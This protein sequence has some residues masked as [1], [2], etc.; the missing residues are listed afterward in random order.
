MSDGDSTQTSQLHPVMRPARGS[1]PPR[2]PP[3]RRPPP[4]RRTGH[5]YH[6]TRRGRWVKRLLATALLI[7]GVLMVSAVAFLLYAKHKID[8]KAVACTTCVS[9]Q[10]A[11]DGAP[12]AFNILVLGSDTRSV[13]SP[14]DQKLFDPTGI[15]KN[16]GQRADTIAVVHVDPASGKA[17][18]LSL[19][20]DLRVQTLDG[21]GYQKINAFYNSGVSAMV[22]AVEK[23]TGLDI[24]HYAEV[25]FDSFRTIT[26]TLGGVSVHFSRKIVDHN[27]GLNQPAGCNLLTGD[28]ALAFVRD[29]DTDSD[30]GRIQRQQLFVKLMLNKVLTPG[31]LLNPVKVAQLMNLG[32]G[33]VTHDPGL[34]LSTMA[35][36]AL[37]FH[38]F[39]SQDLD[40][41]VV[42]SYPERIAG[43]DYVVANQTQASALFSA[44]NHGTTLPAYGIQGGAA[45]ATSAAPT[46]SSIPVTVLNGTGVAGLAA[47][48][49]SALTASGYP[50]LTTHNADAPSYASTVVYYTAGNQAAAQFLASSQIP[51]AQV[52]AAPSA[53]SSLLATLP[54]RPDAVVVMGQNN[55]TSLPAPAASASASGAASPGPSPSPTP[56]LPAGAAQPLMGSVPDFSAC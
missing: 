46:P 50:V 8:E 54:G 55:A 48:E 33:T 11:A 16:S 22:S 1:G 51:N 19:P 32:L 42:P 5:G 43:A 25:N 52:L 36:L 20:R 24:N 10:P 17:I 13:L 7:C 28:Q 29:R 6:M 18:V 35:S 30:F 56:Y 40:F 49:G 14:T 39:S 21:R 31:T 53:I 4:R 15:D 45:S 38:S 27:S 41:R 12:A 47:R 34:S 3:P 23:F 2:R 37:H 9:V 26:D 44:I